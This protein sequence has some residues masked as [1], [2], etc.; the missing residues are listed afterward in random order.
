MEHEG[1]TY[2]L[3]P[4]A[5]NGK[6]VLTDAR[7]W[8]I[9]LQGSEITMIRDFAEN[10]QI[11]FEDS[12][13]AI[14]GAGETVEDP[15]SSERYLDS[16]FL[17]AVTEVSIVERSNG[18]PMDIAKNHNILRTAAFDSQSLRLITRCTS[19]KQ[20]RDCAWQS[21][22]NLVTSKSFKWTLFSSKA[23]AIYRSGDLVDA[24]EVKDY[25]DGDVDEI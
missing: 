17:S 13:D 24:V 25:L 9:V 12:G 3:F 11:T 18:N 23:W 19:G 1:Q 14:V 6:T 21:L 4:A 10:Q 5:S 7:R 2:R 20:E 15:D 8:M 16:S 22:I